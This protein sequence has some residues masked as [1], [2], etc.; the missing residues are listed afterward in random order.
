MHIPIAIID[1]ML[2]DLL[3]DY[4]DNQALSKDLLREY[5]DN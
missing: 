2:K 1:E 3:R 5:S 4:S